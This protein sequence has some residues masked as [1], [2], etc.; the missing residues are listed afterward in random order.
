MQPGAPLLLTPE[1]KSTIFAA[2]QQENK[3]ITPPKRLPAHGRRAA[4]CRLSSELYSLPDGTW[5]GHHAGGARNIQDIKP[6]ILE[7][8]P[9]IICGLPKS[10]S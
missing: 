10:L 3:K 4:R 2:I 9:T 6:V 7:A 1:L 8:D 5:Y